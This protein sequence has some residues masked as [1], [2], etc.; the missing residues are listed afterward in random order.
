MPAPIS[1]QVPSI[2]AGRAVPAE[3]R[4]DDGVLGEEPGER[5]DA[6]DGEVREAERHVGDRHEAGEPA[7]PPHVHLVVHGVHHRARAEEQPGLVE[8][9]REQER[10]REHVA[11]RAEAGAERHVADL[12]HGGPGQRLL[13]VVLGAGDDAAEQQRDRAH[14]GHRQPRVGREREDRVGPHQQVHPGGDHGGRVDQ[15]RHGRGALHRV[16]QPGLQRH[17]GGLAARAEQQQQPQRGG[18]AAAAASA[19]SRTPR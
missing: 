16:Q 14:Q 11:G 2:H 1:A 13:D 19:P 18:H 3:V 17:L 6:D 4:L 12:A 5:R 10:D 7:V 9:V 8:P 15:R